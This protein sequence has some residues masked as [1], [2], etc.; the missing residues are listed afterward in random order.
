MNYTG[1]NMEDV[2]KRNR[3]TILGII[4][5]DGSVSRKQI[6]EI[7]GLTPASVTLLCNEMIEQKM[8]IETG[9]ISVNKGAGRKQVLLE[10]NASYCSILAVNIESENT[11][12][13]LTDL[14]STLLDEK[15]VPTQRK[16]PPAKFLR[17]VAEECQQILKA[18]AKEAKRL[19]GISVCVPGV[20]NKKEGISVR[21]FGVWKEPV[22]VCEILHEMLDVLVII[23]NNVNALA[24]A[25]LFYE[26]SNTKKNFLLIKWGPG[27]GSA[28]VIGQQVYEGRSEKTAEMGHIIIDGD[29]RPC[30]CG[31]K[32]CL[33]TYVSYQALTKIVPFEM[34]RFEEAYTKADAKQKKAIDEALQIFARSI[35]NVMTLLAPDQVILCGKMFHSETV[36]RQLIRFCQ[37]YDPACSEEKMIFTEFDHREEYIGPIACYIQ[38]KLFQ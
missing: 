17:S 37:D 6:S 1:I 24:F 4:A 27:V 12:I 11:Y 2:K 36:R 38:N 8:L 29:G 34:D 14:K 21:A 18:H 9:T 28:I 20:V 30:T 23:E 15:V 3:E 19:A 31:K 5:R 22:E 7:T 10:L 16:D 33:E 13:V 35:V 26:G 32:G 25:Q